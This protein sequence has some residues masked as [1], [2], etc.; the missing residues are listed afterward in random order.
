MPT[1]DFAGG[2]ADRDV[3]HGTP[4]CRHPAFSR[5]AAR[6]RAGL[7]GN[8]CRDAPFTALLEARPFCTAPRVSPQPR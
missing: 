2:K 8:Y 7:L 5:T 4:P 1:T 6:N 3:R